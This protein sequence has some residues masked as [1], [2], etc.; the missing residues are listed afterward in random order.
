M[1][2]T[3][4]TQIDE[5]QL[6]SCLRQM[7]EAGAT[8]ADLVE[9]IRGAFPGPDVTFA[10]VLHLR[11]AFGLTVREARLIEGSCLLGGTLYTV[12]QTEE[13]IQPLIGRSRA[14]SK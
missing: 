6:T 11:R 4:T 8:V 12:E 3:T 2:P 10:V 5:S 1:I 13:L 9:Q 14:M 7:A